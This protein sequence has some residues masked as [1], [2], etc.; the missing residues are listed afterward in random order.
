MDEPEQPLLDDRLRGRLLALAERAEPSHDPLS[1]PSPARERAV[2]AT[3]ARLRARKRARRAALG[4]GLAVAAAAA[5]WTMVAPRPSPR[6]EPHAEVRDHTD[7]ERPVALVA[8]ARA[9][10]GCPLA[11][12]LAM[13]ELHTEGDGRRLAIGRHA[14]IRLSADATVKTRLAHPCTAEV[15]LARGRVSVHARDLSGGQLR[16]RAGATRVLV[17]GTLFAVT[18]RTGAVEVELAEGKL[19]IQRDEQGPPALLVAG[20]RAVIANG[21]L[22]REA[23]STHDQA[24]LLAEHGVAVTTDQNKA[25]LEPQPL[26]RAE[27]APS[28]ARD[29]SVAQAEGLLLRADAARR[30]GDLVTARDLYRK[31]GRGKGTAAE[32]A[33][34]RLCQLE[35]DHGR[36]D[37][38]AAALARYR[39]RFPRGALGAEAAWT[40]IRLAQRRGDEAQARRAAKRLVAE[41]PGVPQAAAARQLL[42]APPP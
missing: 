16:I 17:T 34:M 24:S 12:A 40:A 22:R 36:L 1:P 21:R 2:Q 15:Q 42:E 27:S 11:E 32:A 39:Q 20:E 6:S 26:H 4:S 28:G 5:A 18:A 13:S 14:V 41:H 31:A 9:T 25:D 37:L 29:H 10:D 19:T 7:Q 3:L 38:A 35:L 8:P 33:W 30:R 23:L